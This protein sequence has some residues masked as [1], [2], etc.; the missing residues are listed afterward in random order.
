MKF[1]NKKS[2]KNRKLFIF[3]Y[4]IQNRQT[5]ISNTHIYIS[6]YLKISHYPNAQHMN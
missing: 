3:N 6:F 2:I 1:S 5:C 4:L